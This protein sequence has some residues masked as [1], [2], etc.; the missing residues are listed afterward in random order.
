[1]GHT[2]PGRQTGMLNPSDPVSQVGKNM[3]L[4]IRPQFLERQKKTAKTSKTLYALGDV[5]RPA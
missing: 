3:A 4:I 2:T 1:M 5:Y